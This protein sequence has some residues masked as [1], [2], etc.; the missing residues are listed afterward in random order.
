MLRGQA[1]ACPEGRAAP[2]GGGFASLISRSARFP[3]RFAGF[4]AKPL[5]TASVTLLRSP[6]RAKIADSVRSLRAAPQ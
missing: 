1:G 2:P 4:R 3:V 5:I 6:P